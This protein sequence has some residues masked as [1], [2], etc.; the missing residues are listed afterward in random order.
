MIYEEQG[1]AGWI[2]PENNLR[3]QLKRINKE[4]IRV[5]Q[6]TFQLV[7]KTTSLKVKCKTYVEKWSGD[8]ISTY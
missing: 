3:G 4:L 2:I 5:L 8:K 7:G 6:P 1:R